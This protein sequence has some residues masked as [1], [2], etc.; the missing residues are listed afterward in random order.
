LPTDIFKFDIHPNAD[1]PSIL[2]D[3]AGSD[4]PK[5]PDLD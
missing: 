3:G 2:V 4:I 1:G 5:A